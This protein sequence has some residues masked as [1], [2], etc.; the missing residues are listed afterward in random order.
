MRDFTTDETTLLI[1][2]GI[3]SEGTQAAAEYVTKKEYLNILNQR[4]QQLAGPAELPKYY[5]VLLKV[6]VDNGIPTTASILA[7]HRLDVTRN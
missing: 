2:A 3:K 1:L 7:I 4:L 5:Q 6:D